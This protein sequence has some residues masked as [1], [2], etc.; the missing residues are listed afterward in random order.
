YG[1]YA[2]EVPDFQRHGL[3]G[4]WAKCNRVLLFFDPS[5]EEQE[6]FHA[7]E[8]RIAEFDGVD[9]GSDAFR[10][11]HDAKGRPIALGISTIDLANLGDVVN[12][13]HN[14]LECADWHLRYGFGVTPCDY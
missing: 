9:P 12:S 14:F 2:G 4:L 1:P 6:A 7:V 11:A 13:L 8:A 3:K 5:L 10:F